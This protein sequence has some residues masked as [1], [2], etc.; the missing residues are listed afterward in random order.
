[1]KDHRMK[2]AVWM[3]LLFVILIIFAGCSISY[4]ESRISDIEMCQRFS[5]AENRSFQRIVFG[6]D[7]LSPGYYEG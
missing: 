2:Y 7:L 1:M 3:I 5:F 6:R 4:H